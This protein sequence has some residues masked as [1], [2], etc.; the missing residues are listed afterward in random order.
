MENKSVRCTAAWPSSKQASSPS[1]T[2]L[3]LPHGVLQRRASGCAWDVPLLHLLCK[4]LL[5]LDVQGRA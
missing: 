5:G 3:Q 2:N 1:V 4:T